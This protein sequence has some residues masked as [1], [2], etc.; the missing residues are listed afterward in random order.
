MSSHVIGIDLGT[1]NCAV[2]FARIAEGSEATIND[3]PVPQVQRPGQVAAQPLLPSCIYLP[4]EHELAAGSTA[5]P[6]E[7]SPE[8]IVGEFARWQGARVPGRL[9]S[10]AGPPHSG[11]PL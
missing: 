7:Q 9:V 4:G 8:L 5:L 11:S 1:S 2:A 6:W 3:F 10:G